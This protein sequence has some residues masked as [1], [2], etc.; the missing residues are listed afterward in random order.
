MTGRKDPATSAAR[1]GLGRPDGSGAVELVSPLNLATVQAY[2]SLDAVDDGIETRDAY[3]R[4]GGGNPETLERAIAELEAV[5]GQAAPQ[6]RVTSSGLAALL[7]ATTL[8]VSPSR[9]RI[10]VLRPCYGAT[11]GLLAGPLGNFGVRVTAVDLPPGGGGDHGALV[12]L[13]LGN[14]VAAVVTEVI[15][16]PLVDVV[17][18]PAIAAVCREHGVPYVVDAT[19]ATPFLFQPF[20]HRA[21]LVMHSLTKHLG[22]H[23]D[24]LGGV[25]LVRQDHPAADWLDAHARLVGAGLSSFD[26]WL[27]LR[28]LRTGALRV[29][30]SSRNAAALADWFRGR[31]GVAAVHYPGC[32]GPEDAER[33]E[34]LLPKGRGPVLSVEVYGGLAGA[35]AFVR[36]LQGV[37]LAPSLGDVATTVSHPALTS[38]RGLSRE[39]RTALG[40]TDGLL[41]I[42]TGVEAIDD[43][44][45]EF[46]EALTAAHQAERP[47]G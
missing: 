46:G 21:D 29:D 13:A 15:T 5:P 6:A 26:S 47:G 10:V 1:A 9:K 33:T 38:H 28:G 42:S 36:R 30:A 18:V 41:R 44:Y 20:A 32:R 43:L 45:E 3:R 16:N 4:Y 39:Q 27:A 24:V 8:L 25:L 17:D 37:R 14:D 34:R 40:I 19:F 35:D 2:A 23:S 11:E 22:G 7:L 12:A 31:P